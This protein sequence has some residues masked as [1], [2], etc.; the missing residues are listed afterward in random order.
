MRNVIKEYYDQ[1]C[2]REWKR[3]EDPYARIEFFSTLYM[4]KK[5][6]PENGRV[7]DIGAGPGRYSIELLKRGYKVSLLD[8]SDKCLNLAEKR[9]KDLGLH[10][11]EYICMDIKD[12]SNNICEEYDAIL[13]MG[14]MYHSHNK[15]ERK[16]I[17]ITCKRLL[18]KDGVILI[19]YINSF[20]VLKAGVSEFPDIFNS[21]DEADKY[22]GEL[23]LSAQEG[24]TESY[25]ATPN[26]A[27]SEVE[28]SEFKV[29]SYAGA[30]SFLSG[31]GDVVTRHYIE[32]RNIYLNLLKLAVE[33]CE[34]I[35][36]RDA[37]EHLIIVAQK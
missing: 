33:R 25:F 32:N 18:K 20:G 7:L 35:Q 22:L 24:F 2:E 36:F 6:F 9:I 21:L 5:Y 3:L 12:L 19:S 4:I 26:I 34:D 29:L 28:S 15:E 14:P 31:L 27:L 30:E 17:L 1:N 13:L 8:V 37:T 23:K 10:A 11:E 16:K